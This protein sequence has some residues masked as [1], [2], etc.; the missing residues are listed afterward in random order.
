[1]QAAFAEVDI[2]MVRL[3]QGTLPGE[4]V[5][6]PVMTGGTAGLKGDAATAQVLRNFKAG[7][8]SVHTAYDYF[9]LPEIGAAIA[10]WPRDQL[11]VSSMTSPCFHAAP[12]ARNISDPAACYNLT[13]TEAESLLRDLGIQRLD[14]LMLHG[15]S[16]AFGHV[17]GCT[18]FSCALNAAQWRAYAA[19]LRAGKTRAIGVS[20]F[21]ASCLKCLAAQTDGPVPA[22]NQ[23]QMHVGMGADPDGLMGFN[24][25]RGIIVQAY[26]PLAGGAVATDCP[27]CASVGAAYNKT[28][29]QVGLSWVLDRVP[30]LAVKTGSAEHLADDLALWDGWRLS[31]ADLAALDALTEPKGEA[32]GRCS[33]GCTE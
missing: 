11:F 23:L 12:P 7:L 31:A 8:R 30:T 10:Q 17:G 16:E 13:L 24:S 14:L 22:T 29:A 2:P 26:E 6:M 5:E 15:P 33:W 18:E 19:L 21:C 9:N 1:V 20:N 27:V 32:D 4:M 3:S 28:A 25:V